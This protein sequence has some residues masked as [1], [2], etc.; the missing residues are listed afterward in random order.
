[1][2]NRNKN[3]SGFMLLEVSGEQERFYSEN[4]SYAA[5]MAALGY[6]TGTA[7]SFA[8]PDGHYNI[9][10][11]AQT[12]NTFTLTA[13]PV[14]GGSQDGDACGNF[15]FSNTGA[16]SVSTGTAADCWK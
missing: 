14:T 6:G 7:N 5:N 16:K 11:S 15:S 13:T 10:V 12:A 3:Q 9:S 8:S 1:M 2:L 4:N